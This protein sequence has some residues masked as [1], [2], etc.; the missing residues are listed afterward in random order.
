MSECEKPGCD[1]ETCQACCDHEYDPDE[2]YMCLN[3]G[4]DGL[5]DVM[6]RAYDRAKDARYD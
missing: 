5:E 4:K 3:C 1:G 2:G 6:T